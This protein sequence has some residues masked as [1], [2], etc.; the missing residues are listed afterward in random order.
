MAHEFKNVSKIIHLVLKGLDREYWTRKWTKKTKV[1]ESTPPPPFK[2]K[3]KQS[4]IGNIF[5]DSKDFYTVFIIIKRNNISSI[6]TR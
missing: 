6:V 2:K 5:L 4:L 1:K 3:C